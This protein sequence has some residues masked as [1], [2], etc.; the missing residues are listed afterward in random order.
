M[1][2]TMRKRRVLYLILIITIVACQKKRK[3]PFTKQPDFYYKKTRAGL[4]K[5]SLSYYLKELKEIP[6]QDLSDSLKA[7]YAYVSFRFHNKLGKPDEAI[8]DLIY[9]TS[10]SKGKIKNHR[11]SNYFM[12]LVA[13][14]LRVKNDY[15]NA[16]GVNEKF[17]NLL[18]EDDY[19]Y[20]AYAYG[21]MQRI[22]MAMDLYE[23]ALEPNKKAIEIFLKRKDTINYVISTLDRASIYITLSKNKEAEEQL[24]KVIPYENS[25]NSHTKHQLYSTQGFY[26]NKNKSYKKSIVSYEKALKASKG[27]NTASK[28]QRIANGYLNISAAHLK[29]KNY[30]KTEQYIDS[31]LDLGIQNLSFTDQKEALKVKF[32]ITY[33][34]SKNLDQILPQLDT[35]THHLE[36]KHNERINN[37]L[38]VLRESLENEKNL[39]REKGLAI[40][41][42]LTLERNQY[43][44]FLILL[45]V[46][47]IGVLALNFYRQRKF[48]M[49]KQNFLLQQRLLRSQMNPH[50]IFNSLSL[51]KQS[52]EKN[53]K[54]YSKY[55][56]KLSRLL[57]TVFENSTEDYVPL[58]YELQ[59]LQDY[60]DLQQFRFPDRF[61]YEINNTITTDEELHI[62]PMLLQPFVENAIIHGFGKLENTGH[63]SV[64]IS[65]K[66]SLISCIID[67]NGVGM[68]SDGKKRQSSVYLIDQF[69]TKMTGHKVLIINKNKSQKETGVRV[70]LKIPY[71]QF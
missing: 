45:V 66:D 50:F 21:D 58:E 36:R 71:T 19:V 65:K 3:Q 33:R 23:E 16:A 47:T 25:L 43:I 53:T 31:L 32:E 26:Y 22:K 64:T 10:F 17:L 38:N 42:N 1:F 34:L 46:I 68:I 35:L 52:V 56:I 70:E 7:E 40:I 15:L 49:E 6:K 44:L 63:L 59:S 39:E 9:A 51:I 14:Y 37:E 67:D 48:T 5:D 54:Q 27:L 30:K 28:T 69:L 11:E 57:R 18:E 60:I 20:R 4:Q 29:L 8:K 61:T 12:A 55:I 41:N 62:P 2:D 13:M 24:E